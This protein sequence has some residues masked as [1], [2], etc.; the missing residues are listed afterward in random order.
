[1]EW[2]TRELYHLMINSK[3]GDDIVTGAILSEMHSLEAQKIPSDFGVPKSV[4]G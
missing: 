3:L 2:P 4:R 1:M